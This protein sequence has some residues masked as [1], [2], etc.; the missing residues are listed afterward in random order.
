MDNHHPLSRLR[1]LADRSR[2]LAEY[3]SE[4]EAVRTLL[5][6]A[7]QIDASLPALEAWLQDN[8]GSHRDTANDRPPAEEFQRAH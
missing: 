4:P 6:M 7:D 5:Q 1:G 3:V 8:N 2:H